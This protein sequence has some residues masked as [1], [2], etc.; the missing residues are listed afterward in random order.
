MDN[1]TA[2]LLGY[3]FGSAV[4]I[5]LGA[6]IVQFAIKWLA[7]FKPAYSTTLLAVFVS[8]LACFAVGFVIG[9]VI[10]ANKGEA[11]GGSTILIL[12][13]CFFVQAGCY[14]MMLKSPEGVALSFG[15][16]CLVTLIQVV[17]AGIAIV[18]ISLMVVGALTLSR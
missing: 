16:A 6:I 11:A 18:V 1:A 15:E 9:L 13:A 3:L 12:I 7:G 14:S 4:G 5:F 17:V 10:G 2:S 8:Y